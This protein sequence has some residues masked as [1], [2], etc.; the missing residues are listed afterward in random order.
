MCGR[1][2]RGVLDACQRLVDG[3][4]VGDM[5]R[6][7]GPEVIEADAAKENRMDAVR[8]TNRKRALSAAA[9]TYQ[10][11]S[12]CDAPDGLQRSIHLEHLADRDDALGS[13]GALAESGE[14][15]K[16]V[17]AQ[18]ASKGHKR[19]SVSTAMGC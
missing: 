8:G 15:T 4:H 19:E 3:E 16:L 18:A 1:A 10:K 5:H 13:V 12:M 17:T 2:R 9:D 14:P 11:A 6:P 7:L